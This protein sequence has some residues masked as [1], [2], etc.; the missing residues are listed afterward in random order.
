VASD[1]RDRSRA[2]DAWLERTAR[3]VMRRRSVTPAG[4]PTPQTP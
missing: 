1:L 4:V 3:R 2:A